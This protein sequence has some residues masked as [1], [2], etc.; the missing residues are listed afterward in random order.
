MFKVAITLADALAGEVLEIAGLVDLH[1]VILD[2]LREAA[3]VI[4]LQRGGERAGA[5]V[6]DL[7]G[8]QDFLRGL[9]HA[10]DRGAEL[11]GGVRHAPLAAFADERGEFALVVRDGIVQAGKLALERLHVCVGRRPAP[12]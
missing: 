12:V 3:L 7:G 1:H 5:V 11:A 4:G 6:D 10:L 8:L 2:V 9:F